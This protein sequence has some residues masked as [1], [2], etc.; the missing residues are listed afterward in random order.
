MRF[1]VAQRS[2]RRGEGLG[3]ELLPWAKGWI[4]SQQLD[5]HLVGPSWG[6]NR[7]QYFRNFQT[8]R[9]DFILED[10]LRRLPHSAF[11]EADYRAAGEIDFGAA[12]AK[13]AY[14][15]HLNERSHFIVTVEGM[16]GGYAAIRRARPF[17]W[18]KLLA[19]R[20]A[21]RNLDW[22]L[23]R[24]DRRKLFVAVHL[25]S[26][27]SEFAQH[28]THG[29]LRGK[30]NVSIPADWYRWVCESLTAAFGERLQF[31]FFT[32]TRTAE[33]EEV[34][35]R[36]NPGQLEPQ[37]LSACSDLLLMAMADI[38][39]CSISSYSMAACYLADGPYIWYEPQLTLRNGLYSLWGHEKGQQSASSPT[40]QSESFVANIGRSP[41]CVN[42]AGTAMDIGDSLPAQL[43]Q[44]LEQRLR[45]KDPRTNLLE[46]GCIPIK[47]VAGSCLNAAV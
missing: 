43:V 36:F 28:A 15:R 35:R 40:K 27:C 38:R 3:N 20:D 30:F 23:S 32:D 1:V 11:T 12:I 39:V 10:A 41:A 16:A 26:G 34:A 9:L 18:S 37:G 42:F 2:S 19:S 7:R 8:T 21:L 4:A 29:D 44:L 45:G 47:P 24:L 13:W 22:T 5:A 6:L 25:R 33:F 14:Q 17:L 31:W 46:Y